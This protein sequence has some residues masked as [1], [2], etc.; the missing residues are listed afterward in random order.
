MTKRSI[1]EYQYFCL[2]LN[3]PV[4]NWHMIKEVEPTHSPTQQVNHLRNHRTEKA[5]Y[6]DTTDE[7]TLSRIT[8][9]RQSIER[10]IIQLPE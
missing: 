8:E 10:G 7:E 2:N 9:Y 3:G 4:R 5:H 6:R 1:N